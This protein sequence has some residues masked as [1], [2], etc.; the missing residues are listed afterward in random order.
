MNLSAHD[1]LR[2]LRRLKACPGATTW[3]RHRIKLGDVTA[4][5]I[6]EASKRGGFEEVGGYETGPNHRAGWRNW[7]VEEAFDWGTRTKV[8]ERGWRWSDLVKLM[9]GKSVP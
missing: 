4:R 8:M 3:V 7:L 6:W 9:N 2:W 5:Q 1:F